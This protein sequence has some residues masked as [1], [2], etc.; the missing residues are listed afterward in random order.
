MTGTERPENEKNDQAGA[1]ADSLEIG[2]SADPIMD[3]NAA[4]AAPQAQAEEN[5]ELFLRA[6]AETENVRRRAQEDVAKAHKFAVE[7]FA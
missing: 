1:P 6:R 5:H 3:L 7:S 2:A 4:L